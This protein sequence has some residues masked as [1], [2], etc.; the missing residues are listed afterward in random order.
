MGHSDTEEYT[1]LR[2]EYNRPLFR[3]MLRDVLGCTCFNCGST[4]NVEHHH[5]VPL[6]FGGTNSPK[7][8]VALC[9]R[10]HKAAHHGLHI[11]G[12]T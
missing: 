2:T 12:S 11:T 8:I 3:R 10:C 6:A 1:R 9:D 7:N 5:V 4:T